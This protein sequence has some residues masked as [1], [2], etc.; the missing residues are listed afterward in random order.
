MK[1]VTGATG[2]LGA[3]LVYEILRHE[4]KVKVFHRRTSSGELMQKIFG[5]YS[6]QPETL[7]QRID[8]HEGE[9]TNPSDVQG[10]LDESD[11]LFH[12]AGV[13]SFLGN[14]RKLLREVNVEG[15]RTVVN[16]SLEKNIQKLVHVSSI[17][18]LGRANNQG[19]IDEKSKWKNSRKNT[20]YAITK[21]LGE[22][23]IWRGQMEGLNTAIVNPGIILGPGP[24]DSGSAK[25][26]QAVYN[27]LKYY[28]EGVNGYVDVRD[29]AKAMLMLMESDILSERFI[30]VSKNE[31]YKALF[32]QMASALDCQPPGRRATQ[33]M[34]EMAWRGEAVK[35]FLTRRKPLI[36]KETA[37]TAMKKHYYDGTKITQNLDF[38]Y[39]P[40]DQTIREIAEMF[41]KDM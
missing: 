38:R 41:L 11:Q 22:Q 32:E 7:M 15:S 24:W 25:L 5:Y 26:F 29:V 36:T 1:A 21:M 14:D 18:A 2:L 28:T 19:L 16:A 10:F 34:A 20:W 9:L 37:G 23:E 40:L 12:C 27:G 39:R 13:V 17:A 3:H 6:D 4:E 8:W 31:G 33:F 35:S 30:L